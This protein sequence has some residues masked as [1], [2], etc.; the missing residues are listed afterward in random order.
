M[1][2][3]LQTF[4]AN[5]FLFLLLHFCSQFL[6]YLLCVWYIVWLLFDFAVFFFFSSFSTTHQQK[7]AFFAKFVIISCCYQKTLCLIFKA[8]K[9]Y[10]LPL[11]VSH[12]TTYL[13]SPTSLSQM[14]PT[15]CPP[16]SLSQIWPTPCL[17]STPCE[18]CYTLPLRRRPVSNVTNPLPSFPSLYQVLP[19]PC[20]LP[21]IPVSNVTNPLPSLLPLSQMLPNPSAP[22]SLC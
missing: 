15:P 19:A 8:L 14:L 4:L 10:P 21:P 22:P 1:E 13:P 11:P 7:F 6:Y 2:T 12:V 3:G 18:K 17:T 5:I 9:C 20:P 16:S